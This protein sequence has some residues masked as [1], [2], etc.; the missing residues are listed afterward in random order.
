MVLS[1]MKSNSRPF[2]HLHAHSDY[3]LKDAPASVAD[4]VQHCVDNGFESIALT[5]HGT[6]S[7]LYAFW[8]EC[9]EKGIK[10]ILG[11]E[12]YT[13]ERLKHE[14][15]ETGHTIRDTSFHAVL[16]VKDEVGYKQLCKLLYK[17][18]TETF[19]YKPTILFEDL[20]AVEPG[21]LIISTACIGGLLNKT[22][23]TDKDFVE[24]GLSLGNAIEKAT[25][26]AQ[27]FQD[28]F[29]ADFYIEVQMNELE[30]QRWLNECLIKIAK[31][32]DIEVI[33]TNDCHYITEEDTILQDFLYMLRTNSSISAPKITPSVRHTTY[34]SYEDFLRWNKEHGYNYPVKQIDGWL[35]NTMRI[36]EQCSYDFDTES[37]K[38]PKYYKDDSKSPTDRLRERTLEE[39]K[40]K[41]LDTNE[42]YSKRLDYELEVLSSKGYADYFLIFD[43]IYQHAKEKNIWTSPGRGSAAGCLVSYLLGITKL[44]PIHYGLMFERFLDPSPTSTQLPDIDTDWDSDRRVYIKE[45]VEERWGSKHVCAVG[46]ISQFH[47]RGILRDASRIY[48]IDLDEV[49]KFIGA[50][51]KEMP[52]KYDSISQYLE[53][54]AEKEPIIRKW[55]T[56]DTKKKII[57]IA[58]KLNNHIRHRSKHAAALVIFA[59]PIYDYIP[60]DRIGG[61]TI[62]AFSGGQDDKQLEEL[63]TLK[64]DILGLNTVSILKNTTE[65]VE[66]RTGTDITKELLNIDTK[67]PALYEKI[68]DGRNIGVFQFESR[69]INNLIRAVRPQEFNDIIAISSLH[70][71]GQIDFAYD[72]AAREVEDPPHPIISQH[73]GH[74]RG[75]IVYQ[76]QLMQIIADFMGV[77]LGATNTYRKILG[78]KGIDPDNPAKGS[79]KL[80]KFLKEFY[81]QTSKQHPDLSRKDIMVVVRYLLKYA[82]YGFN[83]SHALCYSYIGLQTLFCKIYYPTEFYCAALNHAKDE[84]EYA[85]YMEDAQMNGVEMLPV[86]F[87]QSQYEFSIE[88]DK[89]IRIGF[90][91]LKGFGKIAYDELA[92]RGRAFDNVVDLLVYPWSK[93][94]KTAIK[95]INAVGGFDCFDVKRESITAALECMTAYDKTKIRA[96]KIESVR[97]KV[98]FALAAAED[99]DVKLL[100]EI[101]KRQIAKEITGFNYYK[102]IKQNNILKKLGTVHKILKDNRLPTFRD[103]DKGKPMVC[104]A[105][106]DYE[107]RTTKNGKE[108]LQITISDGKENN[109]VKVWKHNV[110]ERRFTYSFDKFLAVCYNRLCAFELSH[111]EKW[112]WSMTKLK[113]VFGENK[114]K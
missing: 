53:D 47:M 76:E 33:L 39:L 30:D 77:T 87:L 64:L 15:E 97:D 9:K 4:I 88:E 22:I 111:H 105:V 102:I 66:K 17:A 21:H 78:G 31:K 51:D 23:T 18:N 35:D 3:S 83:F 28:H 98:Q 92:T 60:V 86:S 82:G 89:Q 68:Q 93:F 62:S 29:G 65:L 72:Y 25:A 40:K 32:L 12:A 44:D 6:A 10:P 19:Y 75:V 71:P 107:K 45:Y 56:D 114:E 108:F 63:K 48:E 7:G 13:A 109:N 46:T 85:K 8:R 110:S 42:V 14:D 112:G 2:T 69:S 26:L 81:E 99:G 50:L 70:R 101:E 55:L 41:G 57:H 94:N 24:D 100:S 61:Q 58:D 37:L 73:T 11:C 20:I 79:K 54:K 95:G 1:P 67:D 80:K 59:N 27:I 96:D 103:Y 36:A 52:K 104:G 5:D 113:K 43:D 34:C 16:L 74:T 38:F 90:M 106:I 84:K 49:N 91:A